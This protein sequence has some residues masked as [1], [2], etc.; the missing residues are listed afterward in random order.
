ME[1]NSQFTN[2]NPPAEKTIAL[3]VVEAIIQGW[4]DAYPID[5]FGERLSG[6]AE[7]LMVNEHLRILGPYSVDRLSAAMGRH[8]GTRLLEQ[9]RLAATQ[10]EE[11]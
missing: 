6:Y 11:E 1:T 10:E 7:A 2:P 3:S 4:I 8:M 9:V 5:M